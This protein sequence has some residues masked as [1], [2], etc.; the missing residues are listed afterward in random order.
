MYLAAEATGVT[1]TRCACMS[2][3]P[4]VQVLRAC[5]TICWAG[6]LG[7]QKSELSVEVQD[8]R[9]QALARACCLRC[10]SGRDHGFQV[11][12]E[13][14]E[15]PISEGQTFASAHGPRR[16]SRFSAKAIRSD[17][18]HPP[19]WPD[20]Q[21]SARARGLGGGCF[22]G[23]GSLRLA[24]PCGQQ[25]SSARQSATLQHPCR[26]SCL[27]LLAAASGPG[28]PG[29]RRSST[30][31][32]Q[33]AHAW[34]HGSRSSVRSSWVS[35]ASLSRLPGRHFCPIRLLKFCHEMQLGTESNR[36]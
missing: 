8:K 33:V 7:Q 21:A 4:V 11:K 29:S 9:A 19:G 6:I 13:S 5:C 35:L 3:P 2:L 16:W 32:A 1:A 23:A 14:G 27:A 26:G 15:V 20:R 18:R 24:D 28:R 17:S 10:R 30:E 25:V 22:A 36:R 31:G 34:V 12:A